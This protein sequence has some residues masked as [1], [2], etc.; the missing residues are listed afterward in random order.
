MD[1][2]KLVEALMKLPVEACHRVLLYGPP[3]TGKTTAAHLWARSLGIP[4]Y[5][6]P[7]T[8]ETSAAEI[9]GHWIPSEKGAW[10]FHY[11]P[12][13]M[14]WLEPG[15]L[16]ADEIDLASGDAYVLLHSLVDDMS[17]ASLTLPTGEGV[18]PLPGFRFV[19]TMN[20]DPDSL[21]S[22][23][24]DRFDV[25]IE[26]DC[27]PP[28]AVAAISDQLRPFLVDAE[29]SRRISYRRLAAY[30]RIRRY[31]SDD[32]AADLAL[33]IL[34]PATGQGIVDALRIAGSEK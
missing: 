26:V 22:A 24:L 15:I 2:W 23:L 5:G 12:G 4:C 3:G 11:G 19:G 14:A 29:P 6:I 33:G 28:A 18:K 16:L 25:A 7:M 21:P 31:T 8:P 9:R 1:T 27:P 20:G 10:K 34:G 32:I 30:D 17:T 13:L